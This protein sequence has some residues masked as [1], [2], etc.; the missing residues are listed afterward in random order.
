MSGL[1]LTN[2]ERLPYILRRQSYRLVQG[3]FHSRH[4]TAATRFFMSVK[5]YKVNRVRTAGK[6]GKK[7]A[8]FQ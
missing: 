5:L 2:P 7:P 3:G 6:K 8:V 4:K 1:G